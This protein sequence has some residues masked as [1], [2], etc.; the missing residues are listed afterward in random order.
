MSNGAVTVVSLSEPYY[1]N[2]GV[3][4][5]LRIRRFEKSDL[6]SLYELLSDEEVMRY[7]EPPFTLEKIRGF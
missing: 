5:A 7:I 1:G 6:Q 4:V 2:G 3:I